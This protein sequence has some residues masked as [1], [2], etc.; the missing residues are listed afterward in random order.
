MMSIANSKEEH[1]AIAL[2]KADLLT[3]MVGEFPELQGVIGAIYA[4]SQSE[5]VEVCRAIREHYKPVSVND[6]LPVSK[7]GARIAFFDKLDSLVG[8]LGVGI[9][10]TGSRDP[11]A[12]RRTALSVARI[13]SEFDEDVLENENLDWYIETLIAAYSE[14]G[15]ALLPDTASEV[16]SFLVDRLR[17]YMVDKLDIDS[18]I[19]ECVTDPVVT[20][21]FDYR[22]VLSRARI[23]NKLIDSEDFQILREAYRR[24][25]GIIGDTDKL[26][27]KSVSS[28]IF[29]DPYMNNLRNAVLTIEGQRN[30]FESYETAAKALLEA[31]ENVLINDSNEDVRSNNLRLFSKFIGLV[32]QNVGNLSLIGV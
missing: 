28:L 5:S 26:A 19:V 3:Q 13:L 24:A 30:T 16:K 9:K 15:V 31:C 20:R 1:R 29:Q 23:L 18:D 17:S 14:Q 21:N 2:S 8:L 12:L 22:E 10:P 27:P 11:F 6:D 25:I 4:Q 32:G 7:T